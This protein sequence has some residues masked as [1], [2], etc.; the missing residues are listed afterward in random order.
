MVE[1]G[2]L[3]TI[4]KMLGLDYEYTVFDVDIINQ[5]NSA[6]LTLN[7]LGVGPDEPI[8][9]VDKLQ[10]WSDT[11]LGDLSEFIPGVK[12]YIY[13][14]TRL[15]FD[16]PTTSFA[17][18]ALEKQAAESEWRLNVRAEGSFK[19]MPSNIPDPIVP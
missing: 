6:F 1:D 4:K 7:D 12:T 19:N 18:A 9:I 8:V 5:I 2:I 15:G 16:P 13:I 10:T 11:F 14:K 3:D 17:I